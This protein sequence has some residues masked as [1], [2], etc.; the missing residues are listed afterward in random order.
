[1]NYLK[2]IFAI[3]VFQYSGPAMGQDFS[4]VNYP[5]SAY[6]S[7]LDYGFLGGLVNPNLSNID[8]NND[9]AQDLFVF[10][11]N[12]NRIYTFLHTGEV[13]VASFVHAPQYE[14]MFPQD[15]HDWALLIDYDGDGI[16]DLFTA[17]SNFANGISVWKGSED[18]GI[19]SFELLRFTEDVEES[20]LYYDF[21][22]ASGNIQRRSI[23]VSFN[24]DIPAIT[25]IDGDGDIDILN[26][27]QGGSYLQYHR[28]MSVENNLGLENMHFELGE[29][30]W[31]KIKEGDLDATLTLNADEDVLNTPCLL[32]TSLMS[33]P[34]ATE[35]HSGSS[36]TA[37]DVISEVVN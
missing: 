30:C 4:E 3:I 22:L 5:L 8:F 31:G 19:F 29:T 12:G 15:L 27:E 23:F 35:R 25:D 18:D 32:F 24:V 33:E 10:D 9:G 7:D 6:G 14:S 20:I 1:M 21:P 17:P 13:G 28:N 16:Q 11:R 2:L 36:V 26:F 37:F 34:V